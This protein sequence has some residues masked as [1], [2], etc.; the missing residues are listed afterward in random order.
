MHNFVYLAQRR[1]QE[2]S[3]VPYFF[4]GGG[5]HAP[6]PS[7]LAA[8]L[9]GDRLR[10]GIPSRYVTSQLGKLSLASLQGRLIEYQLRLGEGR[11]CHLCGM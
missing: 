1:S 6:R 8:P 4:F 9:M 5:G 10:A 11:K 3:C 7:P 2:F